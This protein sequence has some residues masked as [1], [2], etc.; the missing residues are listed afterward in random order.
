MVAD[1][2]A[3]V[4]LPRAKI[5]MIVVRAA[6]SPE[7]MPAEDGFLARSKNYAIIRLR[8]ASAVSRA[9]ASLRTV[10]C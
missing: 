6:I 5:A 2:W 10:S 9:A 1:G 7:K 8:A 3:G 4:H